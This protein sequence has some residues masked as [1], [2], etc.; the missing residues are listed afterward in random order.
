LEENIS[1]MPI[2]RE[3][4]PGSYEFGH[5]ARK[6]KKRRVGGF[7]FGFRFKRAPLHTQGVVVV[8]MQ[9][10]NR[11]KVKFSQKKT[12][13]SPA[14]TISDI[15][16]HIELLER[17]QQLQQAKVDAEVQKAKKLLMQK[18]RRGMRRLLL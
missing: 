12:S 2:R 6:G 8:A 18:D 15:R 16:E 14:H 7:P 17:K 9:Y 5:A 4:L 11:I 3:C 13:S 1:V 10:I